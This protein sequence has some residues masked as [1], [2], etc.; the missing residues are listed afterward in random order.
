MEVMAPKLNRIG[1]SGIEIAPTA[2]WGDIG[3]V[4]PEMA[5]EVKELL[6]AN[7]LVVSGVQS[8]L[9]GHP[10][11]QLFNESTWPQMQLHLERNIKIG[12][13]LGANIAVFGSPKNRLRGNLSLDQA[14]E[15]AKTFLKRLIPHLED[16]N[17]ILTLEPNAPEYGADFLTTYTEVVQLSQTIDSVWVKPQIDTGCAKM[18]GEKPDELFQ[19]FEPAHIHLSAPNLK[20]IYPS[21]ENLSLLHLLARRKYKNWIVIEMLH[22]SQLDNHSAIKAAEWLVNE[23]K[24]AQKNVE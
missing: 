15:I 17:I 6:I 23:R 9:F 7:N 22:A 11:F 1:I 16:A 21:K 12:N 24:K 4:T 2:I 8:L 20:Q 3:Q 18:V 13:L 14:N 5:R 19:V 10:E